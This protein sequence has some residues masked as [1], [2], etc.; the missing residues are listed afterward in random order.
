MTIN[1]NGSRK[2]TGADGT[3]EFNLRAGSY[4]VKISKSGYTTQHATVTVAASAV[5]QTITLPVS[6]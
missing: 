2:K 6:T 4:P 1:V 5:T 3:A